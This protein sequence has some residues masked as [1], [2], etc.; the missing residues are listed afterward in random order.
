MRKARVRGRILTVEE[1]RRM[2]LAAAPGAAALLRKMKR[3]ARRPG[4]L[5]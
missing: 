5:P 4:T 2:M 1:I 3:L